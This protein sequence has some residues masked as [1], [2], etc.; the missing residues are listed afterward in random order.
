MSFLTTLS[1]QL[2]Y[3]K[4]WD[5]SKDI[6]D[7]TGKVALV[8]GGN[9]GIG[10]AIVEGLAAHGAKVYMGARSEERAKAAIEKIQDAH[11]EVKQKGLVVWLPLDLTEPSDV[12]KSADDFMG[13]EKRLDI[14]VNNAARLATDYEL[15]KHGIELSVAIN[16]VGH[17]VLV[18]HL[19]PILKATGLRPGSDTRIVIMSSTAFT[20][21]PQLKGLKTVEQLTAPYSTYQDN[22]FYQQCLR[23][24]FTKLL[25]ELHKIELQRCLSS[26]KSDIIVVSAMPGV[27][28]TEGSFATYPWYLKHL[29]GAF[30]VSATSGATSALFGGTAPEVKQ[31]PEKYE[32]AHLT[33]DGSIIETSAQATDPELAVDLW[34]LTQEIIDKIRAK[35]M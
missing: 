30:A 19:M 26:E 1:A 3:G 9:A 11:P 8:T 15:T 22:S 32:G 23:Y 17:F 29:M 20:L 12:I 28:R 35:E 2:G 13:R 25:N 5:P 27:V 18:N 10:A 6:P 24:G 33:V 31:E 34:D 16:H 7:L 4:A 21:C 14:L